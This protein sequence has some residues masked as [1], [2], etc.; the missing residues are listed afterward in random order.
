MFKA[1]RNFLLFIVSMTSLIANAQVF[2]PNPVIA[3]FPNYYQ[4]LQGLTTQFD[5][6]A[7]RQ[8]GLMVESNYDEENVRETVQRVRA[9]RLRLERQASTRVERNLTEVTTT[10]VTALPVIYQAGTA[11]GQRQCSINVDTTDDEDSTRSDRFPPLTGSFNRLGADCSQY[12]NADGTYGS[13]GQTIVASI[14][15]RGED[16]IFYSDRLLGHA[17]SCPNWPNLSN[18]EKEHFWVWTIT[19]IVHAESTCRRGRISARG[20]NGTAVGPLQ[21]EL[22]ASLNRARASREYPHPNCVGPSITRGPQPDLLGSHENNLRCGLDVLE[23]QLMTNKPLYRTERSRDIY[24][25][26]L[27]RPNGGII[28]SMIREN[29]NCASE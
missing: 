15:D 2:V 10:A 23:K 17:H 29:P 1:C 3:P 11:P 7:N 21:M 16:S 12:I 26:K 19:S 18:A 20:T 4:T 24:W 5:S 27:R 25:E 28:G 22:E 13:L 8:Q 14:R 6:L 9:R